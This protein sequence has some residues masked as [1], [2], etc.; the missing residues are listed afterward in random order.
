MHLRKIAAAACVVGFLHIGAPAQAQATADAAIAT[1]TVTGQGE[2]TRPPDLASVAVTIVTSDDNA[3]HALSE[4]NRRFAAL[5]TKLAELGVAAGDVTST[6]LQSYDNPRPAGANGNAAGQG[7]YGFVVTRN[8]AI[9]VRA[10]AQTGAVIDAAT[11]AGATQ[12]NGVSYGLR[13][14][15]SVERAALAAA[16]ADAY[17]QA[18]SVAGAAHVRIV[19]V[20]HIDTASGS[21][22]PVGPL[23]MS[24]AKT[25]E[26]PVPTAIAPSDL[27]VAATVS[28]TYVIR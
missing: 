14:R 21:G 20:L 6:S 22:R 27:T 12:I 25:A 19:R 1:I 4:N 26:A 8:A 2:I 16:V 3:Q 17:A 23:L 9:N 7:P 18:Q 5:G 11:A 24:M 15:R 13:D 10:F 28:A